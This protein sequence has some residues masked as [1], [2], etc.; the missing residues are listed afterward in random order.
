MVPNDRADRALE[1][2]RVTRPDKEEA[3]V[4]KNDRGK[5]I[6]LGILVIVVTGAA[7]FLYWFFIQRGTVFTDD[8][9]FSGHLVDLAPEINGR[10]T[11]LLVQEGQFIQ[12]GELVFQLASS[13]YQAA[14]DQAAAA[15]ASARANL[16]VSQAAL[17][18]IINGS[19]PEEIKA[20]EATLKRLEG[21]EK[22]AGIELDRTKS[23]VTRGFTTQD[24]LD[25]ARTA[26][27]SARHNRE[28]AAQVL[29]MLK[30][31]SRPE[32]IEA[33]R[34]QVEVSNSRVS[35]TE[36]AF[37]KAQS[38]LARCSVQAPFDGWVVRRWLESGSM[39]LPGQPV[40]S[41]FDP[42]TLRV[43]ANIEEK[44]L[45]K[46]SIGD[47]AAITVDAYPGLQLT[48]HVAQI[49]RATN[50]QFSLIP[51]EGVSGTFI[52]VSQRVPLRI[53]L[54]DPPDL[55]LAPGLSVEVRIRSSV[56]ESGKTAQASGHD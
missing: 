1:E 30:Q 13:T 41:I 12:K 29:S 37:M 11:D 19:R 16:R 17:D 34:A 43:D 9:R 18:R 25:R 10:L 51:A 22:L 39:V 50:S 2:S 48:G 28:N 31:G 55:V 54:D 36:A 24:E 42:D 53:E 40:I 7:F 23:L 27:D 38:D 20:A 46:V 52:K 5:R 45:Y 49:L 8:A 33:A 15:L 4:V 6:L 44:H 21:E 35:E 3:G 14:L 56:N 26:H 47:G 32:D